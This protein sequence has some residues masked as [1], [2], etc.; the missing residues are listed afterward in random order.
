M[1]KTDYPHDIFEDMD[2]RL[3][4]ENYRSPRF[5]DVVEAFDGN[6]SF[7]ETGS[8]GQVMDTTLTGAVLGKI[9]SAIRLGVVNG[10]ILI[11]GMKY[12]FEFTKSVHRE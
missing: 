4:A 6:F 2:S 12:D 3:T 5:V 10:T 7:G 9:E 8:N 1:N 11:D